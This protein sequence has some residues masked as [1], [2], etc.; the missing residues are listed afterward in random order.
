MLRF[1]IWSGAIFLVLCT[2]GALYFYQP[3]IPKEQ[4]DARYTNEHSRFLTLS[5]G[6][7]VHY[8]DQ[9]LRSG[10][11][12]VLLHGAMASLHTWEPWVRRLE[13]RYRVITIDLPG[14]GLTGAVNS[15][16][17]SADAFSQTVSGVVQ[18]LGISLFVLGG[19]SMG[20]GVSWR[21]ALDYPD[22]VSKMILVNT[23]APW[24]VRRSRA[25]E[26]NSPFAP[27]G[28]PW[29]RT[30]A[31]SINP[32]I[33]VARGLRLAYNDSPV[34]DDQLVD[35]Y[36]DLIL[37]EGTRA[38]ILGRA[39]AARPGERQQADLSV[40]T[41]P[42][43]IMWGGQDSVISVEVGKR[44][45]EELPDAALVIYPELGHVP[46]EEDP[47]RTVKDVERFLASEHLLSDPQ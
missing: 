47:A 43:L 30:L 41:Q 24:G 31:G 44:L 27:L 10:T 22:R 33:L 21:Y 5:N 28:W 46:M 7:R 16:D 8:R 39:T 11:A 3:D 1:L 4:I 25:E 40:L 6:D 9:G 20:G 32:R 18:S 15:G 14:H 37:R 36:N 35:R 2:A 17:Y 42:T 23:V 38:S 26:S 29:F 34:V 12:V 19:N 45:A 13:N